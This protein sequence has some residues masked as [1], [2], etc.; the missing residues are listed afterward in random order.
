MNNIFPV[1]SNGSVNTNAIY[2][3]G[4]EY[5]NNQYYVGGKR[6]CLKN[7]D[8]DKCPKNETLCVLT[9]LVN[10]DT[11]NC[12]NF[13]AKRGFDCLRRELKYASR[14]LKY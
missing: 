9:N 6:A 1:N 14:H 12:K 11:V 8:L 10:S 13:I 2:L 3:Y 5:I 7:R 4:L